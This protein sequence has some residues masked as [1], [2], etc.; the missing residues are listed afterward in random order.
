MSI[1]VGSKIP[2]TKVGLVK[3]GESGFKSEVIDTGSYFDNKKVVLVAY[4]GAF[5]PTCMNTHIPD[6]ITNAAELK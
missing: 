4:P 6:Y 1:E 2:S 3:Y 5:T